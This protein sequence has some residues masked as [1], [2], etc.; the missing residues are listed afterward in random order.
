MKKLMKMKLINWHYIENETLDIKGSCLITGENGAGKSTILDALQYVLTAGKQRF[1]SAANEKGKRDLIGYVRCKTGKDSNQYERSGDITSHVAL[2]FY[3]ESKKRYFIIGC[4]IDSASNLSTPKTLFYRIENQKIIDNLFF[5][6]DF[7]RNINNF[8]INIKNYIHKIHNTNIEARKDYRNRLGAFN[9]RFFD[10]LPKA[11]AFRPINNVKDFVYSYLLDKKEVNIE[12]LKENVRSLLEFENVLKEIKKKLNKLENI[13]SIYN[14]LNKIEETIKIQDYIIIKAKKEGLELDLINNE[15]NKKDKEDLNNNYKIKLDE[16]KLNLNKRKSY[17]DELHTS[18]LSNDTYRMINNIKKEIEF[19]KQELNVKKRKEIE[20]DKVLKEEFKTAKNLYKKINKFKGLEAFY[21]YK[22]ITINEENINNFI[23]VINEY[24]LNSKII[25]NEKLN[26]RAEFNQKLK[27]YKSKLEDIQKDIKILNNKKLVYDENIINLKNA[28]REEIKRELQKDVE[29]RPVCELLQ[30]KDERWQN[31]VEGYLNTQRFNLIVDSEYFDISLRIYENVKNK[32]KIHGVGLINTQKLEN[33]EKCS[34]ESL[35]HMVTSKNKYAKNYI[36][37]ILGKVTMCEN[38]DELKKYNISITPTCMVYQNYTA[39]QINPKVYNKPYIGI[40]A[41]KKQLELKEEEKRECILKINEIETEI[42]KLDETISLFQKMRLSYIKENSYIKLEVVNKQKELNNLNEELKSIDTSTIIQ[43][44]F[45]LKEVEKEIN[46]MEEQKENYIEKAKES[47]IEIKHIEKEIDNLKYKINEEENYLKEY[48]QN[49][50]EIINK[51]QQR[52]LEIIKDKNP[53]LVYENYNKSKVGFITQKNNKLD[54]LKKAQGEYNNLFHFGGA[55]G[56]EGMDEFYSEYKR[57]K[58]SQIIEYEE[59]LK[60]AKK[61]TEIEFKDH[62]I[63]K[64]QENI[65]L[66]QKEFRKI[67]EALKGIKFGRDEYKFKCFPSKGNEKFYNMIMDDMNIG[68]EFTLFSN[69]F[70]QTHKEAMEELF[71]MIVIDNEQANAALEKYT[72]YRTYMDYDIKIYHEDNT[73]SSF[74]KVCREKS[75][76]ETQTPYYVAIAASFV[77][78][79][80]SDDYRDSIGIILFDEA[81]DKMDENRIESMMTFLNKLNLQI[82]LA[83]PPQK[84][85]LISPYV[86]TTLLV[87]KEDKFSWVEAFSYEELQ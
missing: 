35:A 53:H 21:K 70:E 71:D 67:N 80:S 34:E 40:D 37:M 82:I 19:I 76:G 32:L 55:E 46:T 60:T 2:E 62:F 81:F 65:R 14:Q 31:A 18:L 78:M 38:V 41:Y 64:L 29:P 10:L 45:K 30:V 24:E 13:D 58:D 26:E 59:K 42:K 61:N 84:I 86:K 7:P 44:Q 47:E 63:S 8:K 15:K 27:E 56:I 1:N 20:F 39:R 57:L 69:S 11:L 12:N 83:A 74:S 72:D 16:L 43:I 33:Y 49:N 6:N 73:T 50:I 25:H 54:E 9:D 75:G 51:A 17:K 23:N 28:I 79:Y 52:Y 22:D 3:E 85:E 77:Q 48:E 5:D 87:T 66:A 68:G 36:N 4:V